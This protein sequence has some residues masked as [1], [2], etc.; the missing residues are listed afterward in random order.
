VSKERWRIPR[1]TPRPTGRVK[2][3][4]D[5]KQVV[6]YAGV[7]A[8]AESPTSGYLSPSLYF[9]KFGLYRDV[10]PQPMTAYFDEYRKRR[11]TNE[12]LSSPVKP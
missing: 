7:T 6:D 9:F 1:F 8:N 2:V 10:M 5:R 12:E 11:L 3:R 4:V